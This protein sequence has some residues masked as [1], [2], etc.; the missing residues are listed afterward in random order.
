MGAAQA[1]SVRAAAQASS[2]RVIEV[3]G[4]RRRKLRRTRV[5]SQ[6]P[7]TPNRRIL[8]T[9]LKALI[10]RAF[11]DRGEASARQ[12]SSPLAPEQIAGRLNL[13]FEEGLVMRNTDFSPLYRSMVGFDRLALLLEAASKAETA[14]NW[15]P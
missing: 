15:P 8:P 3:S 2:R 7:L 13:A 11:G 14:S 10:I 6:A 9:P 1:A 4:K 12:R 5:F